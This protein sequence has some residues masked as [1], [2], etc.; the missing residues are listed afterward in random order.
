MCVEDVFGEVK[1]YGHY[2]SR[3][4]LLMGTYIYLQL[5]P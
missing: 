3:F 4:T 5:A 2:Y 1:M